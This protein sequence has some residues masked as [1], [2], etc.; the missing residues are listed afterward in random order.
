MIHLAILKPAYLHAI[1]AGTKTIESRLTKTRQPPHGRVTPGERLFLKASGG[2]FMATAVAGEVRSFDALTPKRIER[3]YERYNKQI[4]GDGTYW[5]ARRDS[6][7]ITLIRL[8]EVEPIAVGPSYKPAYMKA[9]YVLDESLSPVRDWVITAGA[10]RNRYAC[11]PLGNSSSTRPGTP[12]TLLLP[13]NEAVRT[14]LARGRMLRWRGWGSVYERA[15]ARAGDLLRFVSLGRGR[16]SVRVVG[17]PS[18][19]LTLTG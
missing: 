7:F 9:W 6:R 15:G 16:Y 14:D 12:I 18:D 13:G 19:P 4:G 8:T 1:L 10:L 17:R 2:P 11:L 5:R 3:I